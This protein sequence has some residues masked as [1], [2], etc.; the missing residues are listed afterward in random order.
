[1]IEVDGSPVLDV[2][3]FDFTF[4]NGLSVAKVI[5]SPYSPDVYEENATLAGSLSALRTTIT[6]SAAYIAGTDFDFVVTGEDP[7]GNQLIFTFKNLI[8]TGD[9]LPLGN[10]G[11]PVQTLPCVG[12]QVGSDNMVEI[13]RDPIA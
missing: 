4:D 5:G 2:T 12:G 3:S 9:T 6:R 10:A 7:A 1:V 11:P 8:Y 13:E